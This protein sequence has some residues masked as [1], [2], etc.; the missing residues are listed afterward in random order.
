MDILEAK[1]G[2]LVISKQ[3]V[4]NALSD[5]ISAFVVH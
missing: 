2:Y 1:K 3:Y 5:R 4:L